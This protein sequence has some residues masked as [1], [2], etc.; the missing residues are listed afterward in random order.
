MRIMSFAASNTSDVVDIKGD[1]VE[2]DKRA[3]ALFHNCS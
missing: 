2:G 1:I 3:V